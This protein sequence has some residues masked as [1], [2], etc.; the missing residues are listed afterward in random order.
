MVHEGC[1]V[2]SHFIGNSESEIVQERQISPLHS[3]AVSLFTPL[4]PVTL[5]ENAVPPTDRAAP[6]FAGE[7]NRRRLPR[8]A[9]Q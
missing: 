9:S 7:P 3:E 5:L 1:E 6:G 2:C 8:T 4:P